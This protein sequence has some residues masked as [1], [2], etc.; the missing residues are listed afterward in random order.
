[1]PQLLRGRR[2]EPHCPP[3]VLLTVTIDI[4]KDNCGFAPFCNDSDQRCANLHRASQGAPCSALKLGS[5]LQHHWCRLEAIT[6]VNQRKSTIH[7]LRESDYLNYFDCFATNRPTLILFI[8]LFSQSS[9]EAQAIPLLI[10]IL[11]LPREATTG[12]RQFSPLKLIKESFLE[13]TTCCHSCCLSIF[14]SV[15]AKIQEAWS[16]SARWAVCW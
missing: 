1:M 16:N 14:S 2:F 4:S 7:F 5:I 8:I 3:V 13:K 11:F 9:S 6:A 15:R 12:E 10:P